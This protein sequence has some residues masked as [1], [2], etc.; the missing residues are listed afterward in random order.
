MALLQ[1]NPN[2]K[3]ER[4][5]Q[6]SL[7]ARKPHDRDAWLN[8][9]FYLDEQY[10]EFQDAKDGS[11]NLRRIPRKEGEENIPRPV[12]NKIM[13]FIN[14]Q[15]A[16]LMKNK[17]TIDVLPST[18][19]VI[20]AGH[21][22]VGS[23]YLRY[24]LDP[25]NADFDSVSAEAFLWALIAGKGWI[26]WTYSEEEKR[27]DV[28]A[29][30][31]FDVWTDPYAKTFNKARYVGHSQFMDV[32]QIEDIYGVKVKPTSKGAQNAIEAGLLEGMGCAPVNEGS[33]VNEL[34]MKKSKKYPKGLYVV[35]TG[36]DVLVAAQ[37]HPYDHGQLPFT[38]VGSIPRPG[39][40][41]YS[42]AIKWL[43]PP[44]MELNKYHAQ[45][46]MT[47]ES[48]AS[49]KWWIPQELE[50]AKMPDN[51][52]NQILRG[53]GP[54]G[55]K[56]EI[57]QPSNFASGDEGGWIKGEM[58]DVV[59]LHE[60]SQGQVPGRVEAAK[61]IEMLRESDTGRLSVLTRTF[62]SA[63]SK[64]G[65]QALMLARQFV[66]EEQIVQTYTRDGMPEVHKFKT[67][68]F[69]PGWRVRTQMGTGLSGSRAARMEEAVNLWTLGIIRDPETFGQFVELPAERFT[70]TT[71][72]DVKLARNENLEM[73]NGQAVKPNSWDTHDIHIR[74]HNN[75]RKTTEYL[76]ASNE[77]KERFEAHVQ[78]H[79]AQKRTVLEDE[80]KDQQLMAQAMGPPPGAEG[81][82]MEGSAPQGGTPPKQ[83]AGGGP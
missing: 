48:F 51:S 26:K 12:V 81:A 1:R 10:V 73:F 19:D 6:A 60:V 18:D 52:P 35:W 11:L 13:H 4:L 79:K 55:V 63:V 29:P 27:P 75:A 38:E 74:E 15:Q 69:K 28:S 14:S 42:S 37:N 30:N 76:T 25:Q 70:P 31:Y 33:V 2:E 41:H 17:P 80:I 43:R 67:E 78:E 66:P 39:S 50:L 34:W 47:R 61:A 83:P 53:T 54:S 58:M 8:L 16:T 77:V 46:I 49:P 71:A 64:G 23:A 62:Q 32:E 22:E 82:T 21:A 36:S 9:A 7:K 72:M 20:D 45:R 5:K 65:W 56:P 57:I 3:W 44:Q 40:Q 24:L 68:I 59:G